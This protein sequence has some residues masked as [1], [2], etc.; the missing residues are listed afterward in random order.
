MMPG[1]LATRTLRIESG[2]GRPVGLM[3]A[4]NFL[5]CFGAVGVQTAGF[6]LFLERFGPSQ[7]AGAYLVSAAGSAGAAALYLVASGRIPFPRLTRT[8]MVILSVGT[9]IE[10]AGARVGLGIARYLLPMW[11]QIV[12]NMSMLI[13]WAIADGLFDVRQAKRLFGVLSAGR[14][15]GFV[16]GGL[17]AS[18]LVRFVETTELLLVSAG[19]LALAVVAIRA[20]WRLDTPASVLGEGSSPRPG[21]GRRGRSIAALISHHYYRW[22]IAF[23][24]MWWVGF[25][26]IDKIFLGQVV[27][28]ATDQQAIASFLGV[29]YAAAGVLQFV[30]G[31]FVTGRVAHRR[32]LTVSLI[33]TPVLLL[34]G[35]A[36]FA[37]VSG[38]SS[39]SAALLVLAVAMKAVDHGVGFGLDYAVHGIAYRAVPLAVVGRV[40][41]LAEGFGQPIA[42]ASTAFGLIG[43]EQG[44]GLGVTAVGVTAVAVIGLW[45]A[46]AARLGR[47]Y[48]GALA[49]SLARR[50]FSTDRL[51]FAD[52]A[53]RQAL[54][55]ATGDP[56]PAV[57]IYAAR[58]LGSLDPGS[59]RSLLPIQTTHRSA[60]VRRW[61]LAEIELR[62]DRTLLGAWQ[63]SAEPDHLARQYG[64]RALVVCPSDDDDFAAIESWLDDDDPAVRRGAIEGLL[65][66]R[67]EAPAGRASGE[68][69]LRALA[70][71]RI[72]ALS[73]SASESD[74]IVAATVIETTGANDLV[75][76]LVDLIGD[77]SP[78]VSRAA[79][80]A[81]AGLG[82]LNDPAWYG[83]LLAAT[84]RPTC[85]SSAG[86]ALAGEGLMALPAIDGALTA[87]RSDR[88]LV[89]LAATLGR[90]GGDEALRR[91]DTLLDHR[92][93]VVRASAFAALVSA[94]VG[95]S[96]S[97]AV[98]PPVGAVN[99]ARLM[100]CLAREADD[101]ECLAAYI[102]EIPEPDARAL[103]GA[104]R[105]DLF[106][107]VANLVAIAVILSPDVRS[108][109]AAYRLL[110][111]TD[112][113]RLPEVIDLLE[114][115]LS[116]SV[117]AGVIPV[118]ERLAR[119]RPPRSLQPTTL[120]G[121]IVGTTADPCVSSTDPWVRAT[122][123]HLA[124]V[125]LVA[126]CREALLAACDDDDPDVSESARRAIASIDH[127]EEPAMF[128]TVDKVL[129]LKR[130][131]LFAETPDDVLAAVARLV[132][133]EVVDAGA[134]IVREGDLGD[135]MYVIA[136]GRVEVRR[137]GH[138]LNRLS[139][140]D[141]F[142]EMSVLDPGLRSA[143][144]ICI[145]PTHLLLLDRAPLYDL[146]TE[147]PEIGLGIIKVLVGRL[148][149]RV[150]D[151]D[152]SRGDTT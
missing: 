40:A 141:V 73:K 99:H 114:P 102:G 58:T 45:L 54:V 146:L 118:I 26:V 135:E 4:L 84:A 31:A 92:D 90:I 137:G 17:A 70:V 103:S 110:M 82:P 29:F 143:T 59:S 76:T 124:G 41:T 72:L 123:C 9:A 32:G 130:V 113:P 12:I 38:G 50:Q 60:E 68:R 20:V 11:F 122:A 1:G 46:V 105:A 5:I 117:H 97:V 91:I 112:L 88:Q 47:S 51:T 39:S 61:A 104:L 111:T 93:G 125:R 89:V 80:R 43:L 7:I 36:T 134:V 69:P 138:L 108:A 3:V 136:A 132:R 83:P 96:G 140:G 63:L 16:G 66:R 115:E 35:S 109:A 10:W 106:R 6:A 33:G 48:P 128:S 52:P 64:V 21:P 131:S 25:Y 2:E 95:P 30:V 75:S 147:R 15:L 13:F 74:R 53:G 101:V 57:A 121:L 133:Q 24:T 116:V 145:E 78:L 150:A 37:I 55:A 86:L 8:V 119:P 87:T 34:V 42:L 85:A 126:S 142:G 71:A 65:R 120:A 151:L 49:A 23:V 98:M 62:A 19:S 129:A 67:D 18:V 28:H 56:S 14:S 144:V 44:L 22:I 94:T 100:T 107:S 79:I 139:D 77:E 149:D 27:A 148:R 127:Q 81:T 152:T